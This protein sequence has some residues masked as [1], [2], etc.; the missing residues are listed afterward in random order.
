MFA[1]GK[2]KDS[3]GTIANDVKAYSGKLSEFMVANC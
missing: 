1:I 2:M 3:R